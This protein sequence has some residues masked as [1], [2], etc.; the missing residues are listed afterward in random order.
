MHL[1]IS[2]D[3]IEGSCLNTVGIIGLNLVLPSSSQAKSA[4]VGHAW[5]EFLQVVL[6]MLPGGMELGI[7]SMCSTHGKGNNPGDLNSHCINI[8]VPVPDSQPG[9]SKVAGCQ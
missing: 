6:P 5:W 4:L 8:L 2:K 1:L 9:F 3:V 7:L